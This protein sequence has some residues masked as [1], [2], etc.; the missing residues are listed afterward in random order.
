MI[1][2]EE[3]VDIPLL[4]DITSKQPIVCFVFLSSI[5]KFRVSNQFKVSIAKVSFNPSYSL[6]GVSTSISLDNN[7]MANLVCL[8]YIS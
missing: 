4:I 8:G 3:Q 2:M 6:C 5:L 7:S 1:G